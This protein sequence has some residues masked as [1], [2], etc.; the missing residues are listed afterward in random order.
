MMI[1]KTNPNTS[2]HW[3]PDN[4]YKNAFN[5]DGYPF[6]APS[7]R[8][9]GF[10]VAFKTSKS[11][12]QYK[13]RG[14][15]LGFKLI[16]SKPGD[17]LKMSQNNFRIPLSEFGV[18]DIKSTFITTTEKLRHFSPNQRQCFYDDER[19]LRFFKMYSK[20]NCDEE[21]LANYTKNVC[22]CVKFSMPSTNFILH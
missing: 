13:C 12:I 6:Y 7:S 3:S 10:A 17:T 22:G 5:E 1:V 21:C 8:S 9:Y 19:Q 14:L 15:D 16:L 11:D 18:I 20:V 4:G 2:A